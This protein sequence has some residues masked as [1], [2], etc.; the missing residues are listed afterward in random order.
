MKLIRTL[1]AFGV[2]AILTSTALALPSQPHLLPTSGDHGVYA[3]Q[4]KSAGPS[5]PD[6]AKAY[7]NF[8]LSDAYVVDGI[9]WE[10]IFAEPIPTPPSEV[11]F[12]VEIWGVDATNM[13][14]PDIMSGPILSWTLDGGL[15]GASGTDVMVTARAEVSPATATT[16][17]G[18]PAYMYESDLTAETLA[19]GDYWIS[20]LAL[21][22]FD[23]PTE[24]DPEWQWHL[25]SGPGDGF[26]TFDRTL[27]PPGTL[28]SGIPTDSKD[29][30]FTLKG[31]LVPE[32]ASM[33]MAL[34][35]LLS[36]G[37]F[38]RKR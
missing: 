37:L 15:A 16:V 12:L 3:V 34:F 25:G 8:T 30:A 29:L 13:N 31:Q 28:Q 35:G 4:E 26:N 27:M 23:H 17:G 10:G 32:P 24:I 2:A 18:G 22:T 6:L 20:I 21:Q 7:D 11:D 5:D 14:H 36:L 38:R 19:A 9:M 1:A 33:A